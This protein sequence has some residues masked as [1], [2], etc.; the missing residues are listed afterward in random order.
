MTGTDLYKRTYK[1]VPVI[2]EPTCNYH[3][4]VPIG[5]G[6]LSQYTKDTI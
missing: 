1:S 3:G 5:K 6:T 2:F 4:E